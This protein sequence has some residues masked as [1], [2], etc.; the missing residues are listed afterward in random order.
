[1]LRPGPMG[2]QALNSAFKEGA[3]VRAS[4]DTEVL[5][6]CPSCKTIYE[7]VRHHLRPAVEPRCE[8]CQQALP[9]ADEDDWLTYRRAHFGALT[10]ATAGPEEATN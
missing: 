7:S 1:M 5:Y 3:G 6:A 9:L 4:S 10:E 2:V 8:I